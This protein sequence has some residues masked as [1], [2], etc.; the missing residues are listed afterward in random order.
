[1]GLAG[2]DIHFGLHPLR[3]RRRS[4]SDRCHSDRS[5]GCE[6]AQAQ[7]EGEVNGWVL[8]AFFGGFIC[9]FFVAAIGCARKDQS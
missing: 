2:D 9:G 7:L 4:V 8:A 5:E 6:K 3:S 1:M